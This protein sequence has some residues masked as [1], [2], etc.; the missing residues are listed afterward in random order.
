MTGR[1]QVRRDALEAAEFELYLYRLWADSP[2]NDVTEGGLVERVRAFLAVRG[3]EPH[4]ISRVV[5][6]RS[7]LSDEAPLAEVRFAS[8]PAL[9]EAL[10]RIAE[11]CESWEE[12]LTD[13]WAAG[14]GEYAREIVTVY[15][16]SQGNG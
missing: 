6:P 3:V 9:V 15:E 10:N 12:P 14:L 7:I 11:K 2:V 8:V 4:E 1:E 5:E 13:A 16:Q